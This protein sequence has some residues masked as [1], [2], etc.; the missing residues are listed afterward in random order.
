MADSVILRDI[1]YRNHERQ[2]ID[3][4]IPKKAVS[5]SGVILFIH[6]GGW[7]QG[8]KSDYFA[9]AQHFCRLGYIS[10]TMNYRFASKSIN[11]N[12]VLDDVTNALKTLKEKCA[13]YGYK[14]NKL[15]LSGGSAGAHIA[16]L[17][18]YTKKETSPIPPVAAC[19]YCP[20][21]DCT[22]E[23]FL[24]GNKGELESWKYEILSMVCDIEIS[25]NTFL[26][27][28][29]QNALGRISPIN[30]VDENCVPTAIFH[31]KNDELIPIM[32]IEDFVKKL[33]E[34]NIKHDFV[35][36]ENSNHALDQD[37]DSAIKAQDIIKQYAEIHFSC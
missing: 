29:S 37:P 9:D 2:T 13:E 19:C 28:L 21:A 3:I 30:Y 23:D 12:H 17:Y 24:M 31:G 5:D 20:P 33:S 7:T 11:F 8:D 22:K 16:L 27:E 10:A 35:I 36:Y 4:L 25:K 18:A 32:Q 6:G 34:F 1:Q 26:G 15:I 14:L